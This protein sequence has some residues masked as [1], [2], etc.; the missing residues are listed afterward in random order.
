[1]AKFEELK[2]SIKQAIRAN[3]NEEITGTTMQLALL[4][5]IEDLGN[6]SLFK[7]VATI[8]EQPGT[9]DN[10]VFYIA[11][12]PGVYP[13]FGSLRIIG[14]EIAFFV[15]DGE[16]TKLVIN[17]QSLAAVA[18]EK[19]RAML[20]ES[21][22]SQA[23]NNEVERSQTA[24]S[25][26]SE[27]ISTERTRATGAESE[28][29]QAIGAEELR[30]KSAESDLQGLI[31]DEE[32][33]AKEAESGLSEDISTERTRATNAESGLSQDI[34]TER[35][36]AATA[37]AQLR[38]DV[39]EVSENL[40]Q[41]S[42]RELDTDEDF[43]NR[44][45]EIEGKIPAQATSTNQ[46]ADKDF[47]NSSIA[48]NTANFVATFESLQALEEYP[49]TGL[50]N[51]DYA[52]VKATDSEGNTEYQR[53]KWNATN[54]EWKY[55]YTLNN[56]SF[57]QAQ[58]E[59]INS[60]LTSSDVTD[61]RAALVLIGNVIPADASVTN[62]LITREYMEA[63]HIV[64]P[65]LSL[66]AT[67]AQL[68]LV[69]GKIMNAPSN[70]AFFI[71]LPEERGIMS[72]A[73]AK[74]DNSVFAQY[75][76]G[77]YSHELAIELADGIYALEKTDK[78]F[79]YS[80][81]VEAERTRATGVEATLSQSI[82]AE[83][84]RATG[85]EYELSVAISAERTRA[86]GVE[87][88]LSQSISSET[89]RAQGAEQELTTALEGKQPT[90]SDLAE[91]RAA[92][93]IVNDLPTRKGEG[94]KSVLVNGAGT[95]MGLASVVEN[96]YV[97]EGARVVYVE[98]VYDSSAKVTTFEY[99]E[100]FDIG[101]SRITGSTTQGAPLSFVN[102]I[103]YEGVVYAYTLT[104]EIV[105]VNDDSN[106][107]L[108]VQGRNLS[109]WALRLQLGEMIIN[110]AGGE[111]SHA[112]GSETGAFGVAAHAEGRK[113]KANGSYS[114]AEG[115][116][117]TAS[118]DN[119]HTEG[120]FTLANNYSSHAE[121][122]ET[123]ASGSSAHS[124]GYSTIASGGFS[125]AEG[126]GS[127]ATGESAHAEGQ[128]SAAGKGS[129]AEGASSAKKDYSHAEGSSMADGM[130]AH[131]EGVNTNAVG[132]AAHAEGN[133]TIAYNVAEHAEGKFNMSLST[134]KGD[135]VNT[136]HSVGVGV[137]EN[138]RKNALGI[139]DNGKIYLLDI[140][141]YEGKE[142]VPNFMMSL[143]DII[144]NIGERIVALEEKVG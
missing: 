140:G 68:A 14:N 33:R 128:S 139:T 12:N 53:Y 60:G 136:I 109:A 95:A 110:V 63:R 38:H 41:V 132:T 19:A 127:Q 43:E 94:E 49:T 123:I 58:W 75:S 90:I 114:H 116:Q 91:I 35:D 21:N 121:G 42:Q 89:T 80:T 26:L 82:S 141:G 129:H 96:A 31:S 27:S 118:G 65:L 37:E 9:P 86:E 143:Q 20:E 3:G 52:F 142:I 2:N 85:K 18:S 106:H 144:A 57:T 22:L 24:E 113:T 126:N 48:T 102:S 56:S 47:V 10:N 107:L 130:F 4:A 28:L 50:T 67:Q 99:P 83:T 125:H 13:G 62:K 100:D 40:Q 138:H 88:S 115:E 133:G 76:D 104:S 101:G 69:Y 23:I 6:G 137:S 92:V 34:A 108:S 7:G 39:E 61:I 36:R 16:W 73:V 51:N 103:R 11:I 105:M 131:A 70:S 1:M 71:S 25:A 112:E 15:W 120:S 64:L 17:D 74:Q 134:T 77:R 72:L 29:S 32:T 135:I 79:A 84:T 111:H 59:T 8:G 30:A 119:S 81:D 97:S 45:A 124:E 93:G 66:D 46:L 54:A 98:A 5:M 78:T 117:T 44:I 55:E 87:Q 122:D